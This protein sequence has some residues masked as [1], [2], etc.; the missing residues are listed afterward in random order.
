MSTTQ[1][2]QKLA[3]GPKT[4]T[5]QAADRA[6]DA[7][8]RFASR[9]VA[10]RKAYGVATSRPALERSAMADDLGIEP[11]RY[12]RYERGETEPPLWLIEEICRIT[13]VSSA[14]LI[15]D[16]KQ[17]A[18]LAAS[19]DPVAVGLT[20]RRLRAARGAMAE[21]VRTDSEFA[22]LCGST[23]AE[24]AGWLDGK[25]LPHLKAMSGLCE[26]TGLDLDWIY[27][28]TYDGLDPT[29]AIRLRAMMD[30][31]DLRAAAPKAAVRPSRVPE[32]N[33]DAPATSAS[34]GQLA[35]VGG[36]RR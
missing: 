5:T 4:A 15:G 11:E 3:D 13:N 10:L 19:D 30:E 8:M 31:V 2:G 23:V 28:G 12:R 6:H 14:V 18:P 26:K 34:K 9:L 29:I 24:L 21:H 1:P 32:A 33:Q 7:R 20:A 36:G 27:R 25:G 35:G 17:P 16:P 22:R